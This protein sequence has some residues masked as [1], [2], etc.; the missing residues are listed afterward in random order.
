MMNDNEN[1]KKGIEA[2]AQDDAE[3]VALETQSEIISDEKEENAGVALSDENSEGEKEAT[4][5][6]GN[7]IPSDTEAEETER[8][9]E[10][11]EDK[12]ENEKKEIY[13]FR[14]S[15][16]EQYVHDKSDNAGKG[17]KKAKT[18]GGIAVFVT[19]ILIA[20][21]FAAAVLYLSL[22]FDNMSK[23]FA[24]DPNE[25]LSVTEI[26]EKGMPSSVSVYA[27]KGAGSG[28]VG[29][30]FVINEFGY[31]VTNYHVVENSISII[32][33]GSNGKRYSASLIG[34]NKEDDVAVLYAENC[35]LPPV[36]LGNSDEL[37]LGETV[38]AIG[39][40]GGEELAFSVSSGDVSGLNRRV[41]DKR[42]GMI[43][44]NA[45]LNPG[46]SGG[47]LFDSRGNLVGIVTLKY[48]FT[49]VEENDQ[50]LPYDGIAF[51][52][53]IT[54]VINEIEEI[55][56]D[57]LDT[58]KIGITGVS[59]EKGESYFYHNGDGA[60]YY[61]ERIDNADYYI[62]G[63]GSRHPITD[64]LL[65]DSKNMKLTAEET[66]IMIVGVTRGLGADGKLETGDIITSA[67]GRPVT[68]ISELSG[69]INGLSVGD[70]I[71]MTFYRNG[72]QYSETIV[73]MSKRDMLNANK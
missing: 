41:S 56:R 59:V 48:T 43:Q 8:V 72:N 16:D 60:L 67:N 50:N 35:N 63:F 18:R 66:G 33:S 49:N 68:S 2:E 36:S 55:I 52:L 28:S 39:T 61:Y 6:E 26:V 42:L 14:W 9:S 53:P 13:A 5:E 64:E 23:W 58:A 40:P 31:V 70:S 38:V 73:L 62:D 24:G 11:N 51:A 69:I 27:S 29:S 32:V 47:P 12:S 34:Y 71:R 15:Y 45:A 20:F 54:G 37:K 22:N 30:G 57:D 44:T 3:N 10:N 17:A 1:E 4:D 21:A 7:N 46:N 65:R 19:V 25:A